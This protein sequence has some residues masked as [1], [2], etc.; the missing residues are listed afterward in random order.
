MHNFKEVEHPILVLGLR[1]EHRIFGE[2]SIRLDV[3]ELSKA[4]LNIELPI[5]Q[6]IKTIFPLRHDTNYPLR[7]RRSKNRIQAADDLD[8]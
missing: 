4:Q 2:V 1:Q 7:L 6:V 3:F 5:F 8:V